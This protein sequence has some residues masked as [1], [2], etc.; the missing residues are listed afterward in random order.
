[1]GDKTTAIA[2]DLGKRKEFIKPGKVLVNIWATGRSY[3]GI[4][5]R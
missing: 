2:E 5:E 3:K 1:M 4:N